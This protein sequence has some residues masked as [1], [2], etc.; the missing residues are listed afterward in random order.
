MQQFGTCRH[1]GTLT[2]PCTFAL[3]APKLS[4]HFSASI[5]TL[6]KNPETCMLSV[7]LVGLTCLNILVFYISPILPICFRSF[8]FLSCF[9]G[10]YFVAACHI[11]CTTLWSSSSTAESWQLL[12]LALFWSAPNKFIWD[13][14]PCWQVAAGSFSVAEQDE[15]NK[16]HKLLMDTVPKSSTD[17]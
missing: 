14:Q 10:T 7:P 9:F 6:E 3:A 13:T 17:K 4:I 8:C 16:N 11:S 1:F 2:F 15:N 12:C 5:V